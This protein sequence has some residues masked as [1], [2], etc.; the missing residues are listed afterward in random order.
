MKLKN[1]P[2]ILFCCKLLIYFL[3]FDGLENVCPYEND[4]FKVIQPSNEPNFEELAKLRD[5]LNS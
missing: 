1:I 3:I 4:N 2:S 5:L